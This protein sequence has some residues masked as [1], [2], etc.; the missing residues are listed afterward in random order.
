MQTLSVVSRS[1]LN[2]NLAGWEVMEVFAGGV[3]ESDDIFNVSRSLG[4]YCNFAYTFPEPHR[5]DRRDSG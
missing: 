3:R 5:Y 4:S 2:K 1:I